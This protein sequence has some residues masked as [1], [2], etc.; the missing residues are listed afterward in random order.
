M[1]QGGMEI[2][3]TLTFKITDKR[4][5][6]K[7][8]KLINSTMNMV[9]RKSLGNNTGTQVVEVK[10]EQNESPQKC[11]NLCYE[12]SPAQSVIHSKLKWLI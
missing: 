7:T 3:C 2:P 6:E 11:S 5:S 8:H 10:E 12:S 9:E 4:E 1:A